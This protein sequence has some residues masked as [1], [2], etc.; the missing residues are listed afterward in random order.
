MTAVPRRSF[1]QHAAGVLALWAL[2]APAF[3]DAASAAWDAMQ[4]APHRQPRPERLTAE[5]FGTLEALTARLIPS[6]D[7]PGAREA[8]AAWFIDRLLARWAPEQVPDVVQALAALE[9]AAVARGAA[10]FDALP[11]AAQDAIIAAWP[12]ERRRTF[13]SLTCMGMLAPPSHGG[14]RGEVGW[15]LIGHDPAM[16]FRAPYGYYDDPAT[17]ARLVAEAR[18]ARA[19]EET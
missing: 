18:A 1:V 17:L 19:R 11:A 16:A 3:A 13:V 7:G 5:Q 12:A 9:A 6:D 8:G 10:R 15:R 14:N 4:A 2:P